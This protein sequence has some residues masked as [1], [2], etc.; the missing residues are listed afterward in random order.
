MVWGSL[1][2]STLLASG[3]GKEDAIRGQRRWLR[4]TCPGSSCSWGDI[5]PGYAYPKQ[6]IT[7]P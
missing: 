6:D 5:L 1:R 2:L 4:Q 3:P 7:L